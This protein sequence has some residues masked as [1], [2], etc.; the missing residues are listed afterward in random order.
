MLLI[1]PKI[2]YL[3]VT[4]P[5]EIVDAD[6]SSGDVMVPEG[7]TA[8]LRWGVEELIL[9]VFRGDYGLLLYI[10]SMIFLGEV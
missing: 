10:F 4:V 6:S 8:A 3:E 7:G 2:G 9:A 1:C 5:P